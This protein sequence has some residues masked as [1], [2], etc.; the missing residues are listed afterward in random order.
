MGGLGLWLSPVALVATGHRVVTSVLDVGDPAKKTRA[1]VPR[2][3][4]WWA[5]LYAWLVLFLATSTSALLMLIIH[6][7]PPDDSALGLAGMV[8]NGLGA[9]T[10]FGVHTVLWVL[11]AA[12]LYHFERVARL[13]IASNES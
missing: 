10:S 1:R 12:S 11:V 9:G 13:R 5:G 6:P 8:A 3:L 4:S 7:P 2:I